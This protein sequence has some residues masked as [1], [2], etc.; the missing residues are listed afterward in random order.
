[1]TIQTNLSNYQKQKWIQALRS[2]KYIQIFCKF[3][4]TIEKQHCALGV[5]LELFN[6]EGSYT[7]LEKIMTDE[8]VWYVVDLNDLQ[9]CSFELIADKIDKKMIPRRKSLWERLF[10]W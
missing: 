4:S 8:G 5:F 3:S 7:D 2:G 10:S 6:K 1:M 9:R